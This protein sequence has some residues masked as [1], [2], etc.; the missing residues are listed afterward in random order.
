MKI[1]L[2][3]KRI[4]LKPIKAKETGIITPESIEGYVVFQVSKEVKDVKKGD[5]VLY[6][7]GRKFMVQGEEY[8]LTDEENI[9]LC[10]K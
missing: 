7:N 5:N 2:L 9:V 8:I 6:E 3:G 1:Q 4:L 10:Q